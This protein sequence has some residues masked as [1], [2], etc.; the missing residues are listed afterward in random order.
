M[1]TANSYPIVNGTF[2]QADMTL[3]WDRKTWESEFH[4]LHEVGMR[5][6]VLMGITSTAGN[7]TKTIYPS[8]ITG[9]QKTGQVDALDL[10]LSSAEAAGFKVFLGINFNQEWWKKGARDPQWLY[11]QMDRGNLIADELYEL[12]HHKYSGAF[13]GWYWEY[14]VDNLNF[15]TEKELAVLAKALNITLLHLKEDKEKLP[16]LLSPFMNKRYS[17]PE[18]YGENWAF[19]FSNTELGQGDI[20]CP[21]DCVGGGGLELGDVTRWFTALKKAVDTK[22][23]L[24]FWANVESFDHKNWVSAPLKR[25]IKQL[26][27]VSPLVDNCLTFSYSHYYSPNNIDKG[28]HETYLDYVEKG[29]L[30]GGKPAPPG[31]V[32]ARKVGKTQF[33]ISWGP[34]SDDFGICGYL[35]YRDKKLIFSTQ[36]QR[37]YGG[38]PQG[39]VMSYTDTAFPYLTWKNPIYEV[40]AFDF[41]GNVS[42]SVKA[43]NV[44]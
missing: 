37:K 35:L 19:V 31:E 36:A 17:T 10:C 41:A 20:F 23:G 4:Y 39:I 7:V 25:F 27:T 24:L 5:Y 16:L 42:D 43:V 1:I 32:K 3:S 38:D 44:V 8:K 14:E 18:E 26:E 33:L 28:F 29:S 34:A 12:Y 9:F 13:H 22:P 6:L 21:Q 30:E 15:K 40:R 11:R 2:I